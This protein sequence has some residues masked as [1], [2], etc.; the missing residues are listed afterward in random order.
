MERILVPARTFLRHRD[1]LVALICSVLLG[2]AYSFIVPF[3]S[4]FGTVEVGMTPFVFGIFMT[5]TTLSAIA[6]STLLAH[7]SDTHLS[8]RIVLAIGCVSGG[9]GYL[10]YALVR[11]VV[12]L[13]IIGSTL[14]AISAITFSQLFAYARELLARSGVPA[15]ETPLYMNVFRLFFALSWTVGPA[16]ASWIMVF[17]S[18]EGIFVAAAAVF[19]ALLIVVLFFVPA[20]PPLGHHLASRTALRQVLRRPDLLVYFAGFILVFA[21]SIL[22]MMNLPLLVYNTLHGTERDIGIIYSLGPL[23][24]LPLMFYFG[25]V[26]SRGN[27]ERVIRIGVALAVAYYGGLVLVQAPWHIYPLQVLSAAT[28]AVTA[29]VAITFFQ[30]YLPGQPGTATN[31]YSSA[32][33]IGSTAGYLVFGFLSATL[34][35]RGIFVLC[36]V[37][38][39]VTLALFTYLAAASRR[40]VSRPA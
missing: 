34:G 40:P 5:V 33:R 21:A 7:W 25:L 17:Y 22:W 9:L 13:T 35:T 12:W 11:D 39:T 15:A 28:I 14:L 1:L 8:R 6:V 4:L 38:C 20:S 31:L 18:Y 32:Q 16:A 36:A 2:L 3:M 30:N 37:L 23:F 24:E 29:G 26:A 19:A 27:H 10:G